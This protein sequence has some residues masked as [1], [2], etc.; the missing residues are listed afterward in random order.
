VGVRCYSASLK[1][2][3]GT[4]DPELALRVRNHKLALV[5]ERRLIPTRKFE[6][7]TIG[8][9]LDFWWERHGKHRNSKFEYLL[10]RLDSFRPMK[11]RNLSPEMVQD[12][13]DELVEFEKLSPSSANHYRTILNSAFNF[14]VRW[15]KYDD[16]PVAPIPQL[17]ERE[18]RDRFVEVSELAAL[19]EQ[20]Q[21]ENDLELQAFIVLAACTG[22]RKGEIMPRK[23]SEVAIDDEFPYIY[24]AKT[25]NGRSKRLPLPGL[26]VYALR[27]VP[28]Y[29]KHEYL[30]PAK[31]NVRFKDVEKFSK[32]HAWDFGKRFRRICDLAGVHDLRI[33]DLRHFATT[34]LFIEGVAD[35]IIRK[36]TGHRSEELER[37]KHLSPAF[38][39]LTVELIAGRLSRHVSTFLSPSPKN[40]KGR[41]EER[42]EVPHLRGFSGGADGTRTRD[43]RRDRPKILRR[44]SITYLCSQQLGATQDDTKYRETSCVGDSPSNHF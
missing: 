24:T 17:P 18:P 37:Y 39:Q 3:A 36:M 4:T 21:K 7:I 10:F 26:A 41:S 32:P 13:L 22:M 6:S 9:I 11:A 34:M 8:E 16:N 27:Q 23:W 29:G 33:H 25:K 1:E 12:F 20:C 19:I 14:A 28:S 35:A 15:K 31:P 2:A 38:K 5:E 42:P 40:T 30:F 43:L 44:L